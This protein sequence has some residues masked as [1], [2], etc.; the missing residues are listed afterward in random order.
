M[1]NSRYNKIRVFLTPFLAIV[2]ISITALFLYYFYIG[3]TNSNNEN[4]GDKVYEAFI[5][6]NNEA[7]K[8]IEILNE[9]IQSN[10]EPYKSIAIIKLA[11]TYQSIDSNKDKAL[12]EYNSIFTDASTLLFKELASIKKSI[13]FCVKD[14]QNKEIFYS[15]YKVINILNKLNVSHKISNGN[16]VKDLI[17]NI[18]DSVSANNSSKGL[19]RDLLESYKFE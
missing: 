12:L 11:D 14:E 19:A 1:R 15:T 10:I 3:S 6:S 18:R 13:A 7:E 2:F 16:E 5:A 17:I 8:K 4:I 9:V